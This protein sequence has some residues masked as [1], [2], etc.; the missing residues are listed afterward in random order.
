M[1]LRLVFLITKVITWLRLSWWE[2]TWKT[3]Q[4]FLRHRLFV[5]QRGQS[6]RLKLDWAGRAL[7]AALLRIGAARR[8][9]VAAL[10]DW[11]S[12]GIVA[13]RHGKLVIRNLGPLIKRADIPIDRR[14]ATQPKTPA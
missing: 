2:G 14:A 12:R 8:S 6:H 13:R 4:I 11:R 1:C 5:L 3:P 10:R 7:R 9:V